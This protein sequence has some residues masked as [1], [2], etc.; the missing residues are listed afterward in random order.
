[1]YLNFVVFRTLFGAGRETTVFLHM[2]E[3][4]SRVWGTKTP[5]EVLKP[6]KLSLMRARRRVAEG[7]FVA[8][9]LDSQNPVPGWHKL[10]VSDRELY[11]S[12]SVLKF[13][14]RSNI[15]LFFFET[16]IDESGSIVVN[17]KKPSST[18][19]DRTLEEFAEFLHAALKNR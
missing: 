18:E 17:V 19:I 12:D 6:D 11:V 2:R 5:L 16:G 4:K 13:S 9:A 7:K 15:P 3:E 10:N 14:R 8:I 1:F